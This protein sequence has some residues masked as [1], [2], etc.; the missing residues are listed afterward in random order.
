[1]TPDRLS[2]SF[3]APSDPTRR[4]ILARLIQGDSAVSELASPFDM[5]LP[6]SP[7]N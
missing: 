3:A 5:T 2:A 4:S 1:M 6:A 7:S